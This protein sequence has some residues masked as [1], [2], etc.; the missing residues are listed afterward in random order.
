MTAIIAYLIIK[1]RVKTMKKK[2]LRQ[3]LLNIRRSLSCQEIEKKSDRVKEF[4]FDFP[5]FNKAKMVL[6]YI[7]LP[8]EVQTHRMIKDSLKIGKRVAV[9]VVELSSRKITPFEI[10]NPECKLIPGPFNIPE[11][12]KDERYPVS[13]KEIELV[14]VPGVAFDTKGRRL[15]FGGGFYDRFL[16]KL[17][18]RVKSVALAFEC[19]IIDEVPCEEHDVSVDYIITEKRIICCQL[20]PFSKRGSDPQKVI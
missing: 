5:P 17:S 15:G 19:Q 3:N 20:T 7:S 11:P 6:F 9:P 14:I 13:L 10:K 2:T 4:L 12:E 18:S 16:N 1:F 8:S